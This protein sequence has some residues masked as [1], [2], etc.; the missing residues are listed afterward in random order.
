MSGN[1]VFLDTNIAIYAYSI[2]DLAKSQKA[3][4]AMNNNECIISTQVLNEYCNVGIKKLHFPISVIQNDIKDILSNCLLVAV[5]LDTIQ[6]ALALQG[7]FRF[8][9]YDCLMMASALESGCDYLYTEDLQDG[10]VIDGLTIRNI[11]L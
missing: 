10:Q 1:R 7:R 6:Q 8:A 3:K 2:S 5:D 4:V 11:F 9:F